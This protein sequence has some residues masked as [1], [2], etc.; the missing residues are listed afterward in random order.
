M[1]GIWYFVSSCCKPEI[2][3]MNDVRYAFRQ[4]LKNPGFTAAAVPALGVV[5]AYSFLQTQI[6]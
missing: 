1:F 2:A 3:D 4:L 5:P 6:K